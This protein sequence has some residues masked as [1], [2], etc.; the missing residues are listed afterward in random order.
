MLLESTDRNG[1]FRVEC[2]GH[3][4]CNV[5]LHVATIHCSSE[6]RVDL[7]MDPLEALHQTMAIH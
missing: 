3:Y 5:C 1:G 6:Q 2:L 7:V 4:I